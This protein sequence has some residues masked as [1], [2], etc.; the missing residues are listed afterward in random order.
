MHSSSKSSAAAEC[1][2]T[3]AQSGYAAAHKTHNQPEELFLK[4]NTAEFSS[5]FTITQWQCL[6]SDA[7]LILSS[8]EIF[9]FRSNNFATTV[10]GLG[11]SLSPHERH[12]HCRCSL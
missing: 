9:Y 1:V 3:P 2:W 5:G 8:T 7:G 11:V 4:I 6:K 10:S 12:I